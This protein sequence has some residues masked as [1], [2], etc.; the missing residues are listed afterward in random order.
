MAEVKR[1]GRYSSYH[2]AG[3]GAVRAFF[4]G[5]GKGLNDE[6]NGGDAHRNRIHTEKGQDE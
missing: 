5:E 3:L 6:G 1:L 2:P 4:A